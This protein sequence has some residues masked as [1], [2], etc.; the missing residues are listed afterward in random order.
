[1]VADNGLGIATEDLP[2]I[3]KR[4]YRADKARSRDNGN[5]GLG[6][7]ICKAIVD[8]HGGQLTVISKLGEGTVFTLSLPAP[9]RG[10]PQPAT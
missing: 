8:A 6:L 9:A 4:F 1:M 2:K 3:F 10:L 5:S 7:A